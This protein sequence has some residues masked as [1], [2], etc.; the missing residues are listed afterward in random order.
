MDLQTI[1]DSLHPLERKVFPTLK[2]NS[3]LEEIK[4][5]SGLSGVEI[6][7]ALQ[8][9][10]NK[11][12]V[13]LK[14]SSKKIISLD[15]NGKVYFDNGLP[16]R[17]FLNALE[18]SNSLDKIRK[19]AKLDNEEFNISLGLL[20]K[21]GV[22]SLEKGKV[23]LNDKKFL[24]RE[25]DEEALIKKFGKK[26]L[27]LKQLNSKEVDVLKELI[28]RK[29][30]IKEEDVKLLDVQ[31]TSVGEKLI[32]FDLTSK[33]MIES[34]TP[35]LL[36]TGSWKGKKFR[37]YDVKINVPKIYP[38]K[39]HFVNEAKRHAKQIWLEMGF[40]EM[41]GPIINPSFW[42]FDALFVAQDHPTRD[43]QDT[44]FV[45][46]KGKLPDN[47]LVK[48]VKTSHEKNWKYKWDEKLAK[49]LVLRTH[50]TVLSA[51][52]LSEIKKT[53][54]PAKFF[55][56]G[57]NYRN[58]TLDW[59]HLFEFNHTDGIVID[60]DANFKHLLGYLK[61]FFSKMGHDKIRFRPGYFPYTEPSVE[62][63][64]YVP[65]RKTWMELGGA[66]IFRPEMV[67]PLLGENVPVLAWGPGFDRI[68]T[69]YYQIKDIRDLYKNDIKQL[70][71]M[72]AWI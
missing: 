45:R 34:L 43:M 57:R 53:D 14:K 29:D 56:I 63:D 12:L 48:N 8:W 62:I 35:A 66:G 9:L 26:I 7:R 52:T 39:R 50:T 60:P 41:T 23:E 42:N 67:V 13:K 64:V 58:E 5:V 46:G 71:E 15:K 18:A 6:V 51:K 36:R 37:R 1:A 38:G 31:L 59:S 19:V 16:E 65:E 4:S 11:K 49:E 25:F 54:L 44:F 17:R 55:S 21:R 68:I 69:K 70:R 10:E 2:D 30:I 24:E 61:E 27:S 28:K 40:K 72:K 3:T 33:N 32:N 22:I 47:K 20:K